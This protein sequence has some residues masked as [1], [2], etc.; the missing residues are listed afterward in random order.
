MYTNMSKQITDK[1]FNLYITQTKKYLIQH[2]GGGYATGKKKLVSYMMDS[3]LQGKYTVGT[4]AGD[5]QYLKFITFDVDFSNLHMAK[6][7]TYKV[8][9]TLSEYGIEHHISFSGSKG[10]HIDIF[11]EDLIALKSAVK[12]YNLILNESGVLEHSDDGNK[13]EFRPT[14]KQGVKLPMGFHQGTKAFCGFCEVENGLKV[15]SKEESEK[16]F[17]SI[18]KI[19]RQQVLDI[20]GEYEDD[21]IAITDKK[22]IIDTDESLSRYD[23]SQYD[24]S[25]DDLLNEAIDLLQ[26]GLKMQGT[27]NK[28]I[29][30]IAGYLKYTGLDQDEVEEVLNDWI[31]RQDKRNYTTKLEDCYKENKEVAKWVFEKDFQ[32]RPIQY[33]VDVSLNEINAI[34]EK[35]PDKNQK[36]I[37]YAMLIHYKRLANM[38]G[39]FFMSFNQMVKATGTSLSTA[40]RQVES[41]IDIGLVE[42]IERNRKQKGTH[43]KKPNI[44][45]VNLNVDV[46]EEKFTTESDNNFRECVLNFYTEKE[47]QLMFPRRQFKSLI[48]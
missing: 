14:D 20:I 46:S 18:T 37:M 16:Y 8:S 33:T 25:K 43:K 39:V 30:K 17:L 42:V 10:Y 41:L 24:K 5:S 1:L 11:F 15:M 21:E 47:L 13:V 45:R 29:I 38:E 2:S 7:I 36:L 27:R 26:N 28:S 9:D 19:K 22:K 32:I 3:H 4:F 35:C 6:W 48:G 44:Y 12:F 40:M 23:G 34:I 31:D